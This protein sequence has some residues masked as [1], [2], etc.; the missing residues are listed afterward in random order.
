[1]TNLDNNGMNIK[2]KALCIAV[3]PVSCLIFV[4][5]LS[6][7]AIPVFEQNNVRARDVGIP[8]EGRPGVL[9]AITDV[10]GVT[11]GHATL[12]EGQGPVVVG[13]GPVRTGVTAIFPLGRDATH[14]VAAGW[15]SLNGIG[16]MTGS[17]VIRELGELYGPVLLTNT[18]S[19]GTVQSAVVEWNRL[20]IKNTDALYARSLPIVAEAW[21]GFLNDIY[22]QHISHEDVFRA[23]DGASG[24]IV[25]EGNVGAGTGMRTFEFAGGIGTSSRMV[26]DR[27]GTFVVGVLVL[28]NFGRRHQLRIAGVPIGKEITDLMPRRNRPR[29][30]R[31][32]S[33]IVVVATDAPLLPLQLD[34]LSR[35]VALGLARTGSI[36]MD[37]SGDLF[38]AFSTANTCKFRDPQTRQLQMV[39]DMDPLFQATVQC[40]EE[41][42][43]NALVAG[44]TMTGID[45]NKIYAL[46]HDRLLEILRKYKRLN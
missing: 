15:F 28:S 21:D 18:L 34:R 9:N 41:A 14:G 26:S 10:H 25:V 11:V 22:G 3:L 44:R 46:P 19:V 1:M 30:E 31:G 38:I 32:H 33:I 16:E 27:Q 45:G 2:I 42:V 40:T 23:L 13:E 7:A 39:T 36:G 12:I 4:T 37:G 43:I 8:F 5:I 35:R 29:P 24:G 20:Y 17:H 6:R